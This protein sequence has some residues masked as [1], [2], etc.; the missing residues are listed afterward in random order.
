MFEGV[1]FALAEELLREA[2]EMRFVARGE[3][4][5]PAV[6]PG[7]ELILHRARMWD[8][9]VGDVV[10]F[11]QKN[12]WHLERVQEILPG[13]AQ[14]SLLT[15]ADAGVVRKE[16][17]FAE[18]LLGRV[19]FVV[20]DGKE[21]VLERSGS[22]GQRMMLAVVRHLPGAVRGYLALHQLRARIASWR[23]GAGDLASGRLSGS[24]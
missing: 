11:K 18:E 24:V 8:V 4:M 20:R 22:S 9:C 17:V 5:L 13:V 3:G 7:E 10:L 6:F 1:P 21:K 12:R 2:G 23:H 15:R 14:P 16:P 19:A